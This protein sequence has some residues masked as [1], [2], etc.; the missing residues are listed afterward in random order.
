MINRVTDAKFM[1]EFMKIVYNFTR[2][3]TFRLFLSK[4]D[5]GRGGEYQGG[6]ED[7]RV[8]SSGEGAGEGECLYGSISF[9]SPY[10]RFSLSSTQRKL[11]ARVRTRP[12]PSIGFTTQWR[13][14]GTRS[15]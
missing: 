9:T 14:T 13:T 11:S 10:L 8:D 15:E 7:P 1:I 5:N 3:I 6:G 12:G 2:R 4:A